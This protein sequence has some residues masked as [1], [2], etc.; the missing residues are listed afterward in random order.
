[1]KARLTVFDSITQVAICL[2]V[3]LLAIANA[4]VARAATHTVASG[5]SSVDCKSFG[6]GIR[7]GDTVILA[8][9]ARGPITFSDCNGSASNPI[10]IR[11]D[12]SL[13]GPLVIE[14]SGTGFKTRCEN[15][16]HVVI[17]G[18]GKWNGAPSG[19]CGASINEGE[20]VLGTRQCGIV[21]RC[22]SGNP[23][24][25]LRI[26]GSSKFVTIKGVEIDG[27]HPVCDG[28]GLSIND[29][30]YQPKAGEWREGF[31]I[32]NNY[33]HRT[34]EAGMY[35][36]ANQSHDA[37]DD[38]MLRNNE[39]AHNYVDKSGCDGIEYKS[40]IAGSS[41]IH[42]NYVTNTGQNRNGDRDA[43]CGANGISL[44]EAGYTKIFGNYVEAPNPNSGGNGNCIVQSTLNISSNLVATLPVE[45]YNNVLRNC[46]GKG[47]ASTRGKTSNSRLLPTIYN[48]TIVSPVAN[49]GI[50]V[51]SNV[52][53]CTV[54]D[55]ILA[56]V[57][58]SAGE[59]STSR[60][61][62]SSISA[63]KFVDASSNDFRLT[64]ASPAIDSGD[65]CPSEDHVGN[66]RPQGGACDRGAFEFI[67]GQSSPAAK[68]RPPSSLAVE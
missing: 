22:T 42:H 8:G 32:S 56:G 30:Q 54:R 44:F 49:G 58:I 61:L 60:N 3:F 53:S 17:D 20:W 68:P 14:Q 23:H 55:N 19:A 29:H 65:Q 18:T 7:A 57:D 50:S 13:A 39:I 16:E 11:N 15:C 47:I 52:D 5:V 12:T 1:M 6:G 27:N 40:A 62:V 26:S 25:S 45:I 31:V 63:L 43:G 66:E 33:I 9:R 38:M 67:S 10:T 51:N 36:G 34:G 59:C 46:A 28:T 35:V 2:A 64:E 41:S 21:F 37:I 4:P 24:S 48:N